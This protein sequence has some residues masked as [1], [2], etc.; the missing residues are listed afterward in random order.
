MRSCVQAVIVRAPVVAGE[1]ETRCVA[2]LS[3]MVI[4]IPLCAALKGLFIFYFEKQTKRQL[5]SYEGA[6]FQGT[7]FHDEGGDPVPAYDALGDDRFVSESELIANDAAPAA[8]AAP[9]PELDNPWSKLA[10][11]QP[12]ATGMF[13][14]P[15]ASDGQAGK[16]DGA[17]RDSHETDERED[18]GR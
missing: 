16:A 5:V 7:P 12:S 3:G 8:E 17:S 4:A 18:D 6:I 13:R 1:A 9:R 11:L 14:N 15:F 2:L 10:S